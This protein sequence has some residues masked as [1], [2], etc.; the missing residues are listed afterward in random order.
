MGQDMD[1]WRAL[2]NAVM[3]FKN[4]PSHSVKC[5]E[6]LGQLRTCFLLCKDSVPWSQ[7]LN[8]ASVVDELC[9]ALMEQY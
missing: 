3:N 5:E 4:E 1:G 6:F 2:V 9:G 7:V 8:V